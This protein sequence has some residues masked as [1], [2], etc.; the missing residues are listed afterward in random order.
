MNILVIGSQL[1]FTEAKQ[2]FGEVHQ[3]HFAHSHQGAT[4]QIKEAEVVFDFIPEQISDLDLYRTV[5]GVIFFNTAL[6]TLKSICERKK[7]E[8]FQAFGFCGL[9]TFLNRELLE[10]TTLQEDQ[11][12]LE[13]ACKKLKTNFTRV[14]DR[15]GLVTPRIIC[16]IINE[17][18][19]TLEEGTAGR[20]DIDL[21][22]KLGTN[23][24]YGPFEWCEKIGVTNVYDLL[25]AVYEATQDERYLICP[26][27]KKEAGK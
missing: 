3:W 7:T 19:Y 2:K 17:A 20:E 27:L 10:V 8:N 5:T 21:A 13:V 25:A 23:Y 24:P 4:A 15:V 18:Y 11:T 16:M 26:L 6:I 14:A 9:P 12:A 1:N 22:M